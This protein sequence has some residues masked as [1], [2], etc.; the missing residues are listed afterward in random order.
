MSEHTSELF[1]ILTTDGR[2]FEVALRGYDKRQVDTYVARTEDELLALSHERDSALARSADLAAQ[3]ANSHAQIESMRR[4]LSEVSAEITPKNVHARVRPIV[5]LAQAQARGI[6]EL[7]DAE[8]TRLRQLADADATETRRHA[9]LE[10]ER[11]RAQGEA[12]LQRATE[13][14]RQREVAS[15][16]ILAAAQAEA[17]DLVNQARAEAAGLLGQ[18]RAE[19]ETTTAEA[20][21]TR[22]RLDAESSDRRALAD[23]DFEIALRVRRNEE[24]RVDADRRTRAL[25]EA[26]QLVDDALSESD[27]L[28]SMARAEADRIT[29]EAENKVERL[30]ALR[31]RVH[32]DLSVVHS[33]MGRVLADSVIASQDHVVAGDDTPGATAVDPETD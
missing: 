12:D 1:P 7:A 31:D 23:E 3:L 22:E 27:R 33:R 2:E 9:D 26:R 19:V 14:A 8:A 5:E 20:R 10:A 6:R 17:A 13:I 21:A 15:E 29:R 16:E 25:A 11:L 30:I 18:T 32:A 28:M 4:H 24:A